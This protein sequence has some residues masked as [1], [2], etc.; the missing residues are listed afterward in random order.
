M[1]LIK[2][3]ETCI[4]SPELEK[5]KNFYVNVL[6]LQLVSEEIGRSV[7]L[8]TEKSMLLIFNPE[9]TIINS[10]S[11]FPIHGAITPPAIIH[12]DLEIDKGDYEDWKNLLTKNNIEIE[13]ELTFEQDTNSLYFRDPSGNLVEL[14]T[15]GYWPTQN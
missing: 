3:V 1:K 8:K 13:S 7:F 15:Q 10:N 6:G 5:M 11:R 14:I 9:N 2:V 12:F 4:Y